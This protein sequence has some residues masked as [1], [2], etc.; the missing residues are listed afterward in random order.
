MFV[1]DRNSLQ[2]VDFLNFFNQSILEQPMVLESLKFHADP[3]AP[4]VISCPFWANH[5]VVPGHVFHEESSALQP[6]PIPRLSLAS[7]FFERS[8]PASDTIPSI[9]AICPTLPSFGRRASNNSATRGSPPVM[10]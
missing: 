4:S 7:R 9:F 5:P 1:I 2:S 8:V 6:D 3:F 10:S